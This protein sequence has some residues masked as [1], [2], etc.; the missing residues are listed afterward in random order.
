MYACAL[1]NQRLEQLVSLRLATATQAGHIY[2]WD[3]TEGREMGGSIDASRDIAAGRG[4]GQLE[5]E[6]AMGGLSYGVGSRATGGLTS[7][8]KARR[9]GTGGPA[10]IT[11]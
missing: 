10:D 5:I 8:K 3:T 11:Q 2:F 9:D 6:Q 4:Q 7:G 1:S